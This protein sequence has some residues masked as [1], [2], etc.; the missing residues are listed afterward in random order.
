MDKEYLGYVYAGSV[1]PS[2]FR[3][4]AIH[5]IREKSY[6]IALKSRKRNAFFKKFYDYETL[7]E[8]EKASLKSFYYYATGLGSR[9]NLRSSFRIGSGTTRSGSPAFLVF[10][11]RNVDGRKKRKVARL[12]SLNTHLRKKIKYG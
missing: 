8:N 10:S 7:N 2:R 3:D 9:I 5:S 4:S 1:I 6:R 12:N 11:A